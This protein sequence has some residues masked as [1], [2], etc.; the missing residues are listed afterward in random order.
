MSADTVEAVVRVHGGVKFYR[1]APQA[2]RAYV[3][4]DRSR[5]DD[6]YLSEG[7]GVATRLVATPSGVH[8]VGGMTGEVYE[9][10]VAGID[11]DTMTPKGRVRTDDN[12]LRFVEVVVNGPK[13]WSLA[14][15]LHPEVSVALD[16]AQD[17]AAAEIVGWVA[18]HA[19]TRVGPRGRQVQ[20]P[21]ESIEAAVI[22]HYTSR[23]GD[24]HRHLHLQVNARV[25]AAGA[26]RGIH[27]VGI[28]DS[29]E[30]I[31]GI[32]HAAVATDPD[33]RAVLAAH[34]LSVDPETSEI[35]EL[36]P[37]VGAF[38]ARTAQIRQNVDRFEA[39][40]RHEHPGQEP[41]PRLQESW[42]RRAW[43][44]ARPDKVIPKDGRE[45]V[46]R[47]NG[48][49]R[50]IGYRDPSHAVPLRR[51]LPGW[52]DRDAA[53]DLVVSMLGAK[54]SA[55]NTADLRGKTEV[56]L[57]QT[58]LVAEP[59]AR[60]ELAEDITCRAVARCAPLLTRP[61]APEHVRS[62]TSPGVLAVEGDLIARIARRA[63]HTGKPPRPDGLD[64]HQITPV[65]PDAVN[66]LTSDAS[67]V[68][69]E[70]AAGV[71]KT[72]V[73]RSVR[74]LLAHHGQRVVVVTPTMKAADVA[75]RETGAE[76]HSAA[77]LIHQHGW[78]W[79]DDGHWS[80]QSDPTPCASAVVRPGDLLVVDEAGMLDQ[81]TALALLTVA[82][83]TG[84]RVALMGDR[85]Q[86]PAVGRGG[87]LDHA[88][89]YADPATVVTVE[90]VRRF[91]DSAYGILSLR[92]REGYLSG[93]VFE[94]L[95]ARGQIVVHS[96]DV[97]RT[98][99]LARWGAAGDLVMADTREQVADLNAAIRAQRSDLDP[100]A[101]GRQTV[102]TGRGEILAVGDRVATRRNAPDLLVANRQT[103]T[104]T[105]VRADG[106][107][108]LHD[109]GRD[110]VV[111][112]QYAREHVELAYATTVHGA[113]GETVTRAHVALTDSTGAAAAYVCMTRGRASNTAHL[114]AKTLQD[115]KQQWIDAFARD[116]SDLG[117]AHARDD[118]IEAIE[119][120]GPAMRPERPPQARPRRPEHERRHVPSTQ[121]ALRG[122]S[123]GR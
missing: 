9:Q 38:S 39:D 74:E 41:G 46:D 13:T 106:S 20:V 73:L 47:W 64:P 59:A 102:T 51:T 22:R 26:W 81:D 36:A 61:D 113:Q 62:L 77:W 37:Y 58:A 35:R 116:R 17:K 121:S 76:G 88:V 55:W 57:A 63:D 4:S 71:G 12:A 21:V 97:E 103:W 34:G 91:S 40:W 118:A 50:E 78:R 14:A 112:I 5:A 65:P 92:M 100:L 32:G 52:I 90:T 69:V 42:D 24:P 8:S 115:A 16:R 104:V 29:I 107:M 18:A 33:F 109:R 82:D 31:N 93:E 56:L 79:D 101:E 108:V 105:G 87:V 10:W 45:L 6:Y 30:A 85:H 122:S 53:A 7:S 25:W 72:T 89:A 11:V 27:S 119:W 19:T 49:L 98:A 1:G 111:P 43:A 117:P 54:R 80:R 28:R 94:A 110:Q 60:I 96:S 44:Q 84:A 86:L 67:L 120:Y 15:A 23:A 70:G 48:E 3:E 2:A 123:I 114:V 95:L 66:I 99:A 75:A 83:E 68:V